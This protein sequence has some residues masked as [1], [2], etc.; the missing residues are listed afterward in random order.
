MA[1]RSLALTP[2]LVARTTVPIPDP[3]ID[4][5]LIYFSDAY[6]DAIIADMLAQ[7]PSGAPLW[8]FAC[9][10]LIWKPVVAH[11]EEQRGCAHGWHRSFCFQITRFRGTRES[12]GLMMAMDRGGQCHGVLFRLDDREPEVVLGKLFRREFTVKPP[13][14][15]PRWLTVQPEQGAPVQA[16]GFVMNRQ[17]PAYLGRLAPQEVADKLAKACGHVGSCAEYLYNTV[18]HLAERGIYDRNL[19]RLQALVAERIKASGTG[20]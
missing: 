18:T 19:W 11:L 17:S 6:Y 12:P 5:S 13:N 8:L 20:G 9:G 15:L 1:P 16:I 10:S 4:P 14:N 7:R 2:D 3:G